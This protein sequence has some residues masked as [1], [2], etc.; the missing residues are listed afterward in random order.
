MAPASAEAA[1]G[2]RE[3]ANAPS[4]AMAAARKNNEQKRRRNRG[5]VN[6][7]F[8]VIGPLLYRL[9]MNKA[10]KISPSPNKSDRPNDE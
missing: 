8:E 5:D 6:A 7:R 4:A 9:C 2:K 10:R 1:A 3:E